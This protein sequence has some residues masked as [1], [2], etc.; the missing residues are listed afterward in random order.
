MININ[1]INQNNNYSL[2]NPK[3]QT[4]RSSLIMR[5]ST[6]TSGNVGKL[7]PILV[8]EMLPSENLRMTQSVNLQFTPF[9]T[10]VMHEITGDLLTY[11]VPY[12]IIWEDWEKFITGCDEENDEV[13]GT[14]EVPMC[15]LDKN[16]LAYEK[17]KAMVSNKTVEEL[18]V[19]YN[20]IVGAALEYPKAE[21]EATDY[22][23]K[24][25]TYANPENVSEPGFLN[26]AWF[27]N[28]ETA[29]SNNFKLPAKLNNKYWVSGLSSVKQLNE[30]WTLRA[31]D[32]VGTKYWTESLPDYYG[33]PISFNFISSLA[34]TQDDGTIET[35]Y[36][37]QN[38]IIVEPYKTFV[39]TTIENADKAT[40][41]ALNYRAYNKIYNDWIR[42]IDWEPRRDKEDLTIARANNPHD[43]FT[44]ARRYQLRGAMPKV[45]VQLQSNITLTNSKILKGE[46]FAYGF[47]ANA[48]S[49]TSGAGYYVNVDGKTTIQRN[50]AP[51]V[52]LEVDPSQLKVQS[53]LE[54]DIQ[55][56]WNILDMVTPAGLLNYYMANAR[57][58]PRYSEQL[59]ARWGVTIQD[60]RYQY[61]QIVDASKISISQN[62]ITQTAPQQGD[63]TAQGNITGQG[64]GNGGGKTKFYAPEHGV[65]ITL[66]QVRP[67]N[68]YE[69]GFEAQYQKV[70]RFDY[71]TP[72]LVDTP[73]VPI[74]AKELAPN[75]PSDQILGYKGI[76]DEYRTKFNKVTGLLRPSIRGS[77]AVKTLARSWDQEIDMESVVK[78]EPQMSRIKQFT[79]Q[80]DFTMITQTQIITNLP[81]PYIND[82]RIVI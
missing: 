46:S 17:L 60:A 64:W 10:N 39:E 52:N 62:G 21:G 6:Q 44:R 65:L 69:L 43:I 54:S 32:K 40:F 77:L 59:L 11:F 7:I 41:N 3:I 68:A 18:T 45:P 55:G 28:N 13:D 2:D 25:G 26:L 33:I 49:G 63:S 31:M 73:D 1:R 35:Y 56:D 72:E 12:R 66:L 19:V 76:Y 78:C 82:P 75:A 71:P 61:A 79:T 37:H 48:P 58:K 23:L 24:K 67:S 29:I 14:L 38:E 42:Y 80:P 30:F 51:Y 20:E 5:E 22:N 70:T 8:H 47:V 34:L 9:V 15:N 57:I 27:I 4:K 36:W 74:Y 50:S 81:L 16:K 53:E